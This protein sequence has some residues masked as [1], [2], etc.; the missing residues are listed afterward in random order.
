M[1][2]FKKIIKMINCIEIKYQDELDINNYSIENI[3][4]KIKDICNILY[5]ENKHKEYVIDIYNILDN[6]NVKP[7]SIDYM[8]TY[9]N[10]LYGKQIDIIYNKLLTELT[11][12]LS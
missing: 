11:E 12:N 2:S 7:Y 3:I 1:D 9:F 5:V 6:F 10:D 8:T 4:E